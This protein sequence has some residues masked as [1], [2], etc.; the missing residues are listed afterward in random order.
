M[1]RRQVARTA[2]CNASQLKYYDR[3]G[4]FTSMA[5][6]GKFA[7]PKAAGRALPPFSRIDVRRG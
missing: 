5:G 4:G 3:S 1:P 2:G 7:L 6:R